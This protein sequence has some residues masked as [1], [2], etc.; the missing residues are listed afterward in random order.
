MTSPNF[1]EILDSDYLKAL[2]ET[3][4]HYIENG[5]VTS[6]LQVIKLQEEVGEV[7]AALIGFLGSNPRKGVTHTLDDFCMELADVIATVVVAFMILGT[8][9]NPY[10]KR[11]IEKTIQRLNDYNASQP[12][13]CPTC[14]GYGFVSEPIKEG[15]PDPT[16]TCPT[17]NGA[18]KSALLISAS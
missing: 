13:T 7:A 11:Q 2:E 1:N 18:D 10:L 8:D 12:R 6:T 14:K 17:C 3:A 9:P 4:Q 15:D 5:G 16:R